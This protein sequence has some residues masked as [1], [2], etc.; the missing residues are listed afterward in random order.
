MGPMLPADSL[1]MSVVRL[2]SRERIRAKA[3]DVATSERAAHKHFPPSAL[4]RHS[5]DSRCRR[6]VSRDCGWRIVRCPERPGHC[7]SSAREALWTFHRD[8]LLSAKHFFFFLLFTLSIKAV[9]L[10]TDTLGNA[11]KHQDHNEANPLRI[12]LSTSYF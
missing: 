8:V 3:Q 10:G 11:E 2:L 1:E 9:C 6:D 12:H 7:L 5:V 4:S